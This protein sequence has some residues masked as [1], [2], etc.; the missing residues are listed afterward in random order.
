MSLEE[1]KKFASTKHKNLP[2][3]VKAESLTFREYMLNE[4]Q[5]NELQSAQE[6]R[7]V[8]SELTQMFRDVGVKRVKFTTHGGQDRVLARNADVTQAELSN[9]FFKFKKMHLKKVSDEINSRGR[10]QAV[11]KDY[12]SNLNVVID[13]TA[14]DAEMRIVTLERKPPNQF[15]GDKWPEFLQLKVW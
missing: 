4:Q 11:I 5:L 13:L 2:D 10:F 1:L 6:M 14:N 7:E 3:K 15:K 8:E 12:S 9:L